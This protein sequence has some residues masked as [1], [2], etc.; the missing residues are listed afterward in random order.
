[1]R[2]D[3]AIGI[4]LSLFSKKLLGFSDQRVRIGKKDKRNFHPFQCPSTS[5]Y[6]A[7]CLFAGISLCLIIWFFVCLCASVCLST[8]LFVLPLS[9]AAAKTI[10]SYVVV[11]GQFLSVRFQV[12]WQTRGQRTR[13]YTRLLLH[14]TGHFYTRCLQLGP[15]LFF[16]ISTLLGLRSHTLAPPPKIFLRRG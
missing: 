5:V 3:G 6:F 2:N 12:S 15:N 9:E 11:V 7:I 8:C 10:C 1:M 16:P 14:C 4:S 13:P